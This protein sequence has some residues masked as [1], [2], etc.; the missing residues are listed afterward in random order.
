NGTNGSNL[1]I[2]YEIETPSLSSDTIGADNEVAVS[3]MLWDIYDFTNEAGF[4][5]ISTGIG[6]T[7][8]G[9]W[10]VFRN[11]LP[12]T[13]L[14][15]LEDFWDGWFARGNGTLGATGDVTGIFEARKTYYREDTKEPDDT[16]GS[17]TALTVGNPLTS[18]TPDAN[19][20]F[21]P[22][23]D[24]DW[25]SFSYIQ[26]K[27]Y[28]VE[29]TNLGD[30]ADPSMEIYS[31][32]SQPAVC[33]ND[34]ISTTNVNAQIKVH[35]SCPGLT[36]GTLYVKLFPSADATNPAEYGNYNIKITP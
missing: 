21:Y 34:D 29:T 10:D 12:L 9:I 5:T 7:G 11:Y 17:A 25:F 6:N 28:T 14:V 13:D 4:D 31:D 35:V 22:A 8:T 23:G 36:T 27:T 16:A 2:A 32:P 24:V 26:G 20:T 19:L 18:G 15:S 30:G 1:A 3:A 33:T